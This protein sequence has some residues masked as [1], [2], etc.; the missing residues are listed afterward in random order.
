MIVGRSE[1][2]LYINGELAPGDVVL[3]YPQVSGPVQGCAVGNGRSL[4]AGFLGRMS[5]VLWFNEALGAAQ[6]AFL[7]A[8]GPSHMG[9]V[10]YDQI[11]PG[12]VLV[13]LYSGAREGKT[14][15]DTVVRGAA[16]SLT[17]SVKSLVQSVRIFSVNESLSCVG[18]IRMLLP[19]ALRLR[20]DEQQDP[21]HFALVVDM[22]AAMAR[23]N[24][25]SLMDLVKCRALILIGHVLRGLPVQCATA[26]TAKMLTQ[27][28]GSC[29]KDVPI[30]VAQ[31]TFEVLTNFALWAKAP[32]PIQC[33]YWN[34]LFSKYY[35]V[36]LALM[37]AMFGVQSLLD[38]LQFFAW[39]QE[40]RVLILVC[41]SG[42]AC[43]CSWRAPSA[44]QSALRWQT[45]C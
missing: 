4:R 31:H 6:V 29:I 30:L 37:K 45:S 10:E 43:R 33:E 16:G 17:A 20:G 5:S 39:H 40:T 19:L 2:R 38:T 3:P 27:R 44:R 12:S 9:S 7:Y 34:A 24:E 41:S 36:N 21:R 13:A 28:L 11:R 14:L 23:S 22:V 15:S 1:V 42:S 35:C 32:A 26:E 18:G 8:L 25:H